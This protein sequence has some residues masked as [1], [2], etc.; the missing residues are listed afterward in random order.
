MYIFD[1]PY[2]LKSTRNNLFSYIF[3]LPDG[4]TNK[5]YIETMYN[6]DKLK[7]YKLCPKLTHEHIYPNSFQKM[8]VKY[9]SQLLSH[10]T[11]VALN[12]FV[13]FKLLPSESN[14]KFYKRHEGL[15]DIL[16]SS[17]LNNF[18]IFKGTKEQIDFL[19]K[20]IKLFSNLKVI[21]EKGKEVTNKNKFTFGWGITIKGVS[22]LWDMLKEKQYIFLFTK[23]G[24]LREFFG[25]IR[26]CSGNCRNPAQ[27]QFCRAFKKI[28]TLKYILIMRK[29]QIAWKTLA[30]FC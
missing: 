18:H 15:F 7:D 17:H 27:I 25:Q 13:D 16:N 26:N 21:N 24:L 5:T 1:I 28:F 9:A 30:M 4:E 22:E 6:F 29:A 23:S 11:S 19:Q 2:L 12:W 8:K 14:S 20:M 3:R 10:S